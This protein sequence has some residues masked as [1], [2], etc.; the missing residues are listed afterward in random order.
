MERVIDCSD[1]A[2]ALC[3][4]AGW[5]SV[6]GCRYRYVWSWSFGRTGSVPLAVFLG[7]GEQDCEGGCW[8]GWGAV[9]GV[10]L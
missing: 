5:R 2:P 10:V 6:R 7:L 3:L 1:T 4:D 8:M 9:G